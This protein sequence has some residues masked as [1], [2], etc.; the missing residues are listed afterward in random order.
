MKKKRFKN[1]LL[2]NHWA[3]FNQTWQKASLGE[4]DSSWSNK[5]PSF[6][7]RGNNYEIAKIYLQNLRIFF[8]KTIGTILT[9]LGTKPLCVKR[10][11]V[12]SKEGS[13]PFPRGDNNE[14]TKIHWWNLKI[15]F[16]ITTGPNPTKLGRNHPWMKG[17]QGFTNKNYSFLKKMR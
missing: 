3:N 17:S 8:S 10:I 11:Q 13:H 6:F 14:K 4:E 15:S 1:F 7:P 9:K 2:Q 12:S 5:D 16:S